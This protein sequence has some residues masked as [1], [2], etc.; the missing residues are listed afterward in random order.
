MRA[1]LFICM[2]K[3]MYLLNLCLFACSHVHDFYLKCCVYKYLGLF[4]YL[5]LSYL[6]MGSCVPAFFFFLFVCARAC[7]CLCLCVCIQVYVYYFFSCE[8]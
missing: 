2:C 5:F 3:C 1:R 8:F 4:V 6:S 7:V